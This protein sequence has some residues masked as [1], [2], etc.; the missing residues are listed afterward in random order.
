MVGL[1]IRSVW[2]GT[3]RTQRAEGQTR[4]GTQ[5]FLD[6]VPVERDFQLRQIQLKL[7]SLLWSSSHMFLNVNWKLVTWH[8]VWHKPRGASEDTELRLMSARVFPP[9]QLGDPMVWLR[10]AEPLEVGGG[11]VNWWPPTSAVPGPPSC[12]ETPLSGKQ[13]SEMQISQD[14]SLA[15]SHTFRLST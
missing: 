1:Q 15:R 10:K 14:I 9:P 7:H 11:T 4:E 2:T 5:G 6:R 13:S 3:D 12:S 8:Q